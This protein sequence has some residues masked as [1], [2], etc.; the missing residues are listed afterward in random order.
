MARKWFTAEE[1][2]S[3]LREVEVLLA[4]GATAVGS[5]TGAVIRR[6]SLVCIRAF[7]LRAQVGSSVIP[8]PAPATSHAACGFPALRAPARFTSGVMGPIMLEPLVTVD[9]S[10]G[11]GNHQTVRGRH[12]ATAY[13][14][15]SSQSRGATEHGSD[16]VVSSSR[17]S[18]SRTKNIDLSDQSQNNGPS[19]AGSD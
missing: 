3:K 18:F 11:L 1:I 4:K 17:P 5:R 12:K 14:T 13:S 6:S 15:A 19:H 9:D 10:A 8:F 16:G 7:A 2:I